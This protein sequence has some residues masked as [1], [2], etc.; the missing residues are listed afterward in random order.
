IAPLALSL[1]LYPSTLLVPPKEFSPTPQRWIGMVLL[2]RC[3]LQGSIRQGFRWKWV[4]TA[5]VF[6][7]LC[8]SISMLAAVP[9]TATSA[10]INN[11]IGFF[12]SGMIPFLCVRFLIVVRH[13]VLE[14][15]G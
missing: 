2:V 14:L 6:Y 15:L 9:R 7:Y 3:I 1:C 11:R 12:L 8:V 5:A 10:A 4:D 13:R